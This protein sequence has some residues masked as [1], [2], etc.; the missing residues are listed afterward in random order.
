MYYEDN[1]RVAFFIARAFREGLYGLEKNS[2][3]AFNIYR[4]MLPSPKHECS[5]FQ[6]Y[7]RIANYHIG[8]IDLQNNNLN[9]ALAYFERVNYGITSNKPEHGFFSGTAKHT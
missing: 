9:D 6:N 5:I 2:Q 1:P 4:Y 8:E 3:K 7:N